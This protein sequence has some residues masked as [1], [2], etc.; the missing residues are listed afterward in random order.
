MMGVATPPSVSMPRVSGVTS[1]RSTSRPPPWAPGLWGALG[2]GARRSRPAPPLPAGDPAVPLLVE[3]AR[4]AGMVTLVER[5][6]VSPIVR[7]GDADG[8]PVSRKV[9]KELARLRRRL[10]D[11]DD[12]P[13]SVGEPPADLEAQLEE[14]F[15]VEASGWKGVRHT[16]I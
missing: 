12:V 14:G 15:Q 9:H 2:A 10:E 5:Q 16:A 13:F 6:H 1:S 11:E 4:K 7:F 3:A 8:L